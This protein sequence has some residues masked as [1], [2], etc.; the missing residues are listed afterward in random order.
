[1][2]KYVGGITATNFAINAATKATQLTAEAA[3]YTAQA[4]QLTE[5]V[6][7]MSGFAKFLD[8]FTKT[9]S[10][11]TTKAVEL[12]SQAQAAEVAANSASAAG[13]LGKYASCGL[14]GVGVILGVG[15]GA[16][17][18]YKFCEDIL[19]KFVEYFKNNSDKIKNSYK[20][21]AEYFLN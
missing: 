11:I 15:C 12:T 17:T 5:Q 16:Y 21:A 9:G 6:N 10:T 1:M 3:Q 8:F 2:G 13:T 20:E 18:T 7:N 4:A 19:D 14:F